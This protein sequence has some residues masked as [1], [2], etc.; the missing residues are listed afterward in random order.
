MFLGSGT[1][2]SREVWSNLPHGRV[3]C[4]LRHF[5]HSAFVLSLF[6][7]LLF[8]SLSILGINAS[9]LVH[10]RVADMSLGTGQGGGAWI[11]IAYNSSFGYLI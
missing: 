1:Y 10:V 3:A 2:G 7:P 8:L 5:L 9:L 6:I 4:F 11:Y